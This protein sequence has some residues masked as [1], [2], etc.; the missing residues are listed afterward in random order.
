MLVLLDLLVNW[1]V[2]SIDCEECRILAVFR[3][4]RA[5]FKGFPLKTH[6]LLVVYYVGR[7]EHIVSGHRRAIS[8][9]NEVEGLSLTSRK[10]PFAP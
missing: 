7:G 5:N 10:W 9:K 3:V 2:H 8:Y 6:A 4:E 1:P